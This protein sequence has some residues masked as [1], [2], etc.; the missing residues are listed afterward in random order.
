[1]RAGDLGRDES[2]GSVRGSGGG[3]FDGAGGTEEE[4][5]EFINDNGGFEWF[6]IAFAGDVGNGG[7]ATLGA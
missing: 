3:G 4:E 7:G 6:G 5:E 1:M 2:T